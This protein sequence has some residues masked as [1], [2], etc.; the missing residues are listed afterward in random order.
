MN[1]NH[2]YS[3]FFTSPNYFT[4]CKIKLQPILYLF[5]KIL[6]IIVLCYCIISTDIVKKKGA[7][8]YIVNFEIPAF[9]LSL[10]CLTYCLT[11]KRRQYKAPKTL[12]NKFASQHFVFLIMYCA[13]LEG[14]F[15]LSF[16][17]IFFIYSVLLK[18]Y[19]LIY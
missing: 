19:Y 4:F 11:A 17:F 8:M 18:L 5:L 6:F 10:F 15:L 2:Y 12:K 3:Y 9:L 1:R 7:Y 16:F 13:L 14:F